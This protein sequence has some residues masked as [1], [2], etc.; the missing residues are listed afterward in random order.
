M[1]REQGQ[2][3]RSKEVIKIKMH[4]KTGI[5]NLHSTLYFL[6]GYSAGSEN[7]NNFEVL[8][9]SSTAF[10]KAFSNNKNIQLDSA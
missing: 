10:A 2:K 3:W 6:F 4:A 8:V 1:R 5:F 9:N 7:V